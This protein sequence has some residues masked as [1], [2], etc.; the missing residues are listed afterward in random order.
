MKPLKDRETAGQLLAQKL[1]NAD[2]K[3]ASVLALPRGGVPI[4]WEIAKE[5][6]LPLD[7]LLVKKIGEPDQPEFAIGAV[8]EDEHPIWNQE[9]LSALGLEKR[10]LHDLSENTRKIILEQAKKWRKGRAPLDVK[11]KTIILVDDGLAT[12][13][14]MH[15]AVEF[16]KRRGVKKIV[17]AAPVAS[18]SA[19]DSF[20][21]KVDQIVVLQIPEPFFS[22]G[23]WYED[24][25]QVTDETVTN[26]LAG[27]IQAEEGFRPL[28]FS[29]K[30]FDG[31]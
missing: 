21:T 17:I 29:S 26:I 31:Q 7:V 3:E 2:W 9:S 12:G 10:K 28:G 18:R 20:K 4:A 27:M 5:L 19:V 1:K 30:D 24:F 25:T 14:T 13:M 15:A 6:K 22:V 8:S 16:L 11:D 23:Q